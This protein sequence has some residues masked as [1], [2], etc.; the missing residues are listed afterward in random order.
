MSPAG[1]QGEPFAAPPLTAVAT[2][3]IQGVDVRLAREVTYRIRDEVAGEIRHPVRAVPRLDVAVEPSAIVWPLDR[4]TPR[5]IAITVTS[6]G[7]E[8]IS[9]TVEIGVPPGWPAIAPSA[10]S[11][12]RKG[13]R[14]VV[15]ASLS[16]HGTPSPGRSE[17]SVAAV[18]GGTRFTT[19]IP[20]IDYEHIRPTPFP[21]AVGCRSRWLT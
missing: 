4:Q 13:D 21:K 17:I 15:E 7:R 11:L 19:T 10:F 14:T 18:A 3:R 5:S 20:L 8:P 9:G 6:N 1:L 2:A 12:S 16:P